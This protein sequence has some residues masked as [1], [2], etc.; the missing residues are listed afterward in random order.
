MKGSLGFARSKSSAR[1]KEINE[2]IG[3]EP[4]IERQDQTQQTSYLS[5]GYFE[6]PSEAWVPENYEA[7]SAACVVAE[8]GLTGNLTGAPSPWDR[9]MLRGR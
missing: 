5:C 3:R 8:G 6:L 2:A 9:A 7:D 1:G 4:E